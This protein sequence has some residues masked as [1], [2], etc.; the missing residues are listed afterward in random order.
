MDHS[1][2]WDIYNQKN[3]LD[4]KEYVDNNIFR[5]IRFFDFEDESGEEEK[6]QVLIDYFTKYPEQITSIT[7]QTVG[8]P[9]QLSVPILNNIGGV[10]KYK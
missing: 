7:V 6:K 5:L 10:I 9:N 4:A 3:K 1:D 8:H 2:D